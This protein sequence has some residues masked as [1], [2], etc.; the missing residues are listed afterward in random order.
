MWPTGHRDGPDDYQRVISDQPARY[1]QQAGL[2]VTVVL[3]YFIQFVGHTSQPFQ[4]RRNVTPVPRHTGYLTKTAEEICHTAGEKMIFQL[5]Y[6]G[7]SQ[8]NSATL[9]DFF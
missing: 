6:S 1:P 7:L 4:N 5:K 8:K 9:D 3:Y 2:F